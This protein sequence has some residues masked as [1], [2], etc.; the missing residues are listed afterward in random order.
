M[1][2][3]LASNSLETIKVLVKLDMVN[4]SEMRMCHVFIILTLAFIQGH[5]DLNHENNK[6]SINTE[7]VQAMPIKF[8]VKRQDSPTKGLY[9]HCKSK[10]LD[11][12]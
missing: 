6:C 1:C 8:A 5:T 3:P 12:H 4:T 9:G 7:T 11:L 2:V 10:D